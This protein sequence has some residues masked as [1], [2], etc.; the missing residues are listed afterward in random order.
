M[1]LALAFHVTFS[2][3]NRVWWVCSDLGGGDISGEVFDEFFVDDVDKCG[4]WWVA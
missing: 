1:D 4:V 3:G 2:G